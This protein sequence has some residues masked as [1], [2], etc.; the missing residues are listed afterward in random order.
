MRV[1]RFST[2]LFSIFHFHIHG[3]DRYRHDRKILP[4]GHYTP[5]STFISG[6]VAIIHL[7]G[8][9]QLGLA[10]LIDPVEQNPVNKI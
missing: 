10:P 3:C 6:L 2:K 9:M 8:I 4:C 7:Q 5:E 1:K